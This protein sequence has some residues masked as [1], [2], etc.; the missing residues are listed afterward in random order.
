MSLNNVTLTGNLTRGVDLRYTPTGKPVANF[1][2]AVNRP[3]KN[4]AGER[5]AD[6]ID[7]VVWDKLAELCG[8]YLDKG[9]KVGVSGRLQTRNYETSDGQRRKVCEVVCEEIEFLSRKQEE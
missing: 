9:S 7:C 8:Q 5:E 2:I 3:F 6:F 1:G 4:S